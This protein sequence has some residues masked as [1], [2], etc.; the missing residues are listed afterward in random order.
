MRNVLHVVHYPIFGGPHNQALRLAEPLR[1]RG[2]E[3]LVLL[4]D[5]PGNAAGRLRDA[6]IAVTMLPLHRLRA[7]PN[8]LTQARFASHFWHGVTSIRRLIR[9]REIALTVVTSLTNPHAAIAAQLEQVPVTWQLIDTRPPM[10]LRRL[11]MPAVLRL[12]DSMMSTGR[13]V[14]AVHPGALSLG[15]RLV[16]FFPPVDTADF[17]PSDERRAA[18]RAE[19]GIGDDDTLAGAVANLVPPKGHDYLLAAA[20]AARLTHGSLK[21]R[22]LGASSPT[23]VGHE[24]R[25]RELAARL[26][27]DPDVTFVDPGGRVA[28]LLPAFD[29]AVMSAVPRS[30]GITT[31]LL[32]AMSC[33]VPVVATDI[34]A[35]AEAVDDGANG[36][37]VPPLDVP[38]LAWAI[39]RLANDAELRRAMG[40][41]GRAKALKAFSLDVCADTHVE[42]FERAVRH[43]LAHVRPPAVTPREDLA[44]GR[45]RPA[46]AAADGMRV[47]V[48]NKFAHVTGGADQ[49]VIGLVAAL[50]ERGHEVRV[51]TTSSPLN[52]E[53]DGRFVPLKVTNATRNTLPPLRRA[54]VAGRA[55]WNWTA[56]KEM[57]LLVHEFRP[58]VVHVHK[59]YPQLSVAPL[60]VASRGGVPIVHTLHDLELVAANPLAPGGEWSD[61]LEERAEY[62]AL[63]T[64]TFAI[65]RAVHRPRVS[66]FV[67]PSRYVADVHRRFGVEAEV[68]PNFT[69]FAGRNHLPGFADRDGVLFV[70]RLTD[71]KRPFDVVAL[72]RRLPQHQVTVSG[73]GPLAGSI[74]SELTSLPNARYLGAADRSTLE[75]LLL[76]A[77][78]MVI[79]S[80]YPEIGPLT[81]I[82]AMAFGTPVVAYDH[83]GLAEYVRGA[84]GGRAVAADVESLALAAAEIHDD[85]ELWGRLSKSGAEG[86][87]ER[88]SPGAYADRIVEVYARTMHGNMRR[89]GV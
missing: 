64:A 51:L 48:V 67:A 3:T 12:S 42:A 39:G 32:E 55:V 65:R 13:A 82:E 87:R 43:R 89:R 62:R 68:I 85:P 69:E 5:E 11:L 17:R 29:V 78:V 41:S 54:E 8:L 72:A 6:G 34:G 9:E 22:I 59:L 80:S 21:L 52:V 44:R 63:N 81:A 1:A 84:G 79:P 15:E 57:R 16:P 31:A 28:E 47:V 49:H 75:M 45:R 7:S 18:A 26:G 30:E 77:R 70:G 88:H 56:A 24:R 23:H 83:S 27:F 46:T 2:W 73:F 86:V 74:S 14:A 61:R 19:L 36:L 35:V 60:V 33:G 40:V 76:S 50:R 37:L 71:H 58:D 38:A 66:A 10:A 53:W 25:L 20:A 4:P